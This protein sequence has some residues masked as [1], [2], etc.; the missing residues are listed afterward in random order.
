MSQTAV[1]EIEAVDLSDLEMLDDENRHARCTVCTP[2]RPPL[3]VP[4]VAWCGT[5]AVWLSYLTAADAVPV[6]ACQDCLTLPTCAR[7][8][9]GRW[10][11]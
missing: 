8:G 7:C 4:F 5:K 9:T 3:G 2:E 1:S 11:P 6:N 10:L